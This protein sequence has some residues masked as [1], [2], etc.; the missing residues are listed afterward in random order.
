MPADADGTA[1]PAW[2][3]DTHPDTAGNTHPAPAANTHPDTARNSHPAPAADMLPGTGVS[4]P[5]DRAAR[6]HSETGAGALPDRPGALGAGSG[7]VRAA[8]NAD[9]ALDGPGQGRSAQEGGDS[10]GR[11]LRERAARGPD[12]PLL[13]QDD[14]TLTYG[15]AYERSARIARALVALGAGNGT[16]VGLLFANTAEFVVTAFAVARIGAVVVPLSTFATAGEL[17]DHLLHADVEILLATSRYRDH[18]YAARITGVLGAPPN[19]EPAVPLLNPALPQLRQ[20]IFDGN[21]LDTLAEDIAPELL[22]AVEDDVRGSDVLS[23][24]YT[25]GSTDAPKGVLHTHQA[26]LG[27]QRGLNRVRGLNA[28]DRLFCN[29]PFFW[30]GGFAYALLATLTAGSTLV[31]STAADAGRTLDLLE[32]VRPSTANGFDAGVR[33][34]VRHPSFPERDLSFL[35]R[36]NLYSLMAAQARPA[37]RELRHNMLGMTEAGSV[38]LLSG[39]ESDQPESRRGSFGRPA[40][41]YRIRITDPETGEPVQDGRAG[42]LWVR[43]PHLMLGY[44]KRTRE[45]SFTA[46]GWFRTGDLARTDDEGFVYFLGRRSAMIKTAGADVAPTEVERAIATV[47][48]GVV[49]HVVGLPDAER[50]RI[51][52]AV[53]V[54][55]DRPIPDETTLRERLRTELSAYKVPRRFV[56][57]SPADLPLRAGGKLDTARLTELFDSA[58]GSPPSRP[59]DGTGAAG[60]GEPFD[61]ACPAGS[62]VRMGDESSVDQCGE[63]FDTAADPRPRPGGEVYA[64]RPADPPLAPGGEPGAAESGGPIDA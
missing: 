29:S 9:S 11:V 53:L 52:A 36:G 3:A 35:R 34:L 57:V 46:D 6:T 12:H 23:L 17:C 22:A 31:C 58:G 38:L 13:I 43:G 47:T 40:P 32:R 51:V 25:S 5:P 26:L 15:A 49:A 42:E 27:H 14:E 30:I 39:D 59:G 44:H 33:Y 55:G 63:L 19:P 18:D 56:T 41:G 45:E 50:D 64:A 10:L 60:T 2:T 62:P 8:D 37:D 54:A 21:G 16:H 61:A 1:P 7:A 48:G 28:D 20:V 24:I 4:P